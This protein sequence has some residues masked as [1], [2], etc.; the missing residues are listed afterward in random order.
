MARRLGASAWSPPRWAKTSSATSK[1]YAIARLR[2]E[3]FAQCRATS[4]WRCRSAAPSADETEAMPTE[5]VR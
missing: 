2:P 3:T 4:A 5:V 1:E